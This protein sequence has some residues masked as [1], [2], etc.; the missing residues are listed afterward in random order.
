MGGRVPC[1]ADK[2]T[3]TI[4]RGAVNDLFVDEEENESLKEDDE[5]D[6]EGDDEVDKPKFEVA[7]LES[8]LRVKYEKIE[9]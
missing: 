3:F 4:F 2:R 6:D 5:G 1:R 9:Y 8:R 7:N